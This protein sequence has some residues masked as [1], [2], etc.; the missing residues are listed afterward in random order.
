MSF[1]S[2]IVDR[3]NAAAKILALAVVAVGGGSAAEVVRETA[4]IGKVSE[5]ADGDQL[6]VV[7]TNA[8]GRAEVVDRL[9]FVRD[10][11]HILNAPIG[12]AYLPEDAKKREALLKAVKP[13]IIDEV[14][15]FQT[16][17]APQT[18]KRARAVIL[19]K[20][21][22]KAKGFFAASRVMPTQRETTDYLLKTIYPEV[23][24]HLGVKDD[25]FERCGVAEYR[26]RYRKKGDSLELRFKCM[27]LGGGEKSIV[28]IYHGY[29]R[30]DGTMDAEFRAIFG[31]II[32]PQL[33]EK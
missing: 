25:P 32:K 18:W 11:G 5:I 29:P 12:G 3:L 14:P 15:G 10:L 1:C 21:T 27:S 26:T 16:A 17:T 30:T 31:N 20:G 22:L 23:F 7:A 33:D 28:L 4:V 6:E 9:H 13:E 19:E 24:S 8:D 2:E